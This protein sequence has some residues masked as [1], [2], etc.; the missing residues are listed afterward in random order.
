MEEEEE[1]AKKETMI[2]A[3]AVAAVT[4]ELQHPH[5]LVLLSNL[6][7]FTSQIFLLLEF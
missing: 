3:L 5:R 7:K 2:V 4:L 1:V 6:Q